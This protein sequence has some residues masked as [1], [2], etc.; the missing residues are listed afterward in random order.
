VEFA[1]EHPSFV[2]SEMIQMWLGF[3]PPMFPFAEW[4]PFVFSVV[5]FAY[6]GL[7]FLQHGNP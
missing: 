2:Y 1:A 7:P 6:G 5:I 4:I 3:M